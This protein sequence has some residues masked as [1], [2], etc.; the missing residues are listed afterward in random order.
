MAST[1]YIF[2]LLELCMYERYAMWRFHEDAQCWSA[3]APYARLRRHISYTI[4]DATTPRV[5]NFLPRF[6]DA[7]NLSFALI[8]Y[9]A[10]LFCL[11]GKY[12]S[13]FST[14][15]FLQSSPN[16]RY[17]HAK[18]SRCRSRSYHTFPTIIKSIFGRDDWPRI[19]NRRFKYI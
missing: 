6:L 3:R 2:N 17:V 19:I 12:T 10:A 16:P 1:E 13:V 8:L 4:R 14:S 5:A 15:Y 11:R 18:K 7:F 9:I